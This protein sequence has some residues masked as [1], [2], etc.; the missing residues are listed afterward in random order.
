MDFDT[1]EGY[2]SWQ[3]PELRLEYFHRYDDEID[4]RRPLEEWVQVSQPDWAN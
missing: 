2:L 4:L 1:G 3:H